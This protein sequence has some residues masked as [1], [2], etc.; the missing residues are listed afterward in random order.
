MTQSTDR[1]NLFTEKNSLD[2]YVQFESLTEEDLYQLLDH[3][4][5]CIDMESQPLEIPRK[6][7]KGNPYVPDTAIYHCL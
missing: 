3:D 1:G 7:N 5:N 6:N 2:G 4:P